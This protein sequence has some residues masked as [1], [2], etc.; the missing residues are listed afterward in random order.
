VVLDGP[1]VR[2]RRGRAVKTFSRWIENEPKEQWCIPFDNERVRYGIKTTNFAEVY[3]AVLHGARA[4]PLVGIIDFFLYR[5]MKYFL[6]RS[7]AAHTAM[8]NI[9]LVYLTKM[10]EYLDKAQK[11]LF[12]T[13]RNKNL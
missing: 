9:Q 11:R 8:E 13:E 12:F 1:N 5:T 7:N 4:L 3:S 10:I 6:E 2:Q